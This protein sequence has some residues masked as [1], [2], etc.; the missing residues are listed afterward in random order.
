MLTSRLRSPQPSRLTVLALL[1]GT[2]ATASGASAQELQDLKKP[3]TPLVLQSQVTLA[4]LPILI[5]FGDL[6]IADLIL[7]WIDRNVGTKVTSF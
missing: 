4:R 5:V 2:L 3:A 1:A 6:Q 7:N